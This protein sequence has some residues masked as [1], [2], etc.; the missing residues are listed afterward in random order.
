MA[1]YSPAPGI[2]PRGI[3]QTPTT[4]SS[5]THTP[6]TGLSFALLTP[7]FAPENHNHFP[8]YSPVQPSSAH[9]VTGISPL[10]YN[11]G[12]EERGDPPFLSPSPQQADLSQKQQPTHWQEAGQESTGLSLD[13]DTGAHLL[14]TLEGLGLSQFPSSGDR[15]NIALAA[16]SPGAFPP[17]I[18]L[19]NFDT[20]FAPYASN[21]HRINQVLSSADPY[22]LGVD[23]EPTVLGGA[24][25][26]SNGHSSPPYGRVD[27]TPSSTHGSARAPQARAVSNGYDHPSSWSYMEQQFPPAGQDCFSVS[28]NRLAH[29]LL[30]MM[31]SPSTGTVAAGTDDDSYGSGGQP[32]GRLEGATPGILAAAGKKRTR[33]QRHECKICGNRFTSRQ[34]LKNHHN[35]HSGAKP[36]QCT[37]CEPHKHYRHSRSLNRHLKKVHGI[38]PVGR[39]GEVQ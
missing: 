5:L 2:H 4:S 36:Y 11:L 35:S 7:Y 3:P 28:P 20:D 8:V 19:T 17:H 16:S 9:S 10:F 15:S 25:S 38:T 12:L 1:G 27:P 23:N 22:R 6:S 31:A 14:E 37:E 34:N 24:T 18:H 26:T 30:P 21:T 33:A 39:R 13:A 29:T 32:A